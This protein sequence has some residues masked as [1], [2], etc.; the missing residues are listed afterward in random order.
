[1]TTK[2]PTTNEKG[3][4]I[5]LAENRHSTSEFHDIMI[6]T[7]ASQ[8]SIAGY[9]QYLALNKILE[10]HLNTT[11]GGTVNVQFSIGLT[12]S[13]GSINVSTPVGPVIFHVVRANTPFTLCL[14][15]MDSLD[16]FFNNMQDVLVQK[17]IIFQL[18]ENLDM[19]FY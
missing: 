19:L 12:P 11:T 15:D 7:G 14:K 18:F 8:V 3:P 4:F 5:Y 9:G 16:V 17:T 6:D 1:M 13:I 10:T 2:V